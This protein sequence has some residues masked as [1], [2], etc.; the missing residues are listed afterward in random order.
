M[1]S[2]FYGLRKIQPEFPLNLRAKSINKSSDCYPLLFLDVTSKHKLIKAGHARGARE[3]HVPGSLT[4]RDG[5]SGDRTLGI[6]R[7]R[8]RGSYGVVTSRVW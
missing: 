7:Y 5:G 4:T 3:D 6:G 8:G 1:V 2:F